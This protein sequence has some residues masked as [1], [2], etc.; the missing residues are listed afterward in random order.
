MTDRF[1][2]FIKNTFFIPHDA[3]SVRSRWKRAISVN[4]FL[5]AVIF[6]LSFICCVELILKQWM[7]VFLELITIVYFV[8]TLILNKKGNFFLASNLAILGVNFTLFFFDSYLG[9]K[10]GIAFYY[11]P[12]F[13]S[14]P[15]I[16][17]MDYKRS[18]AFHLLFTFTCW[19]ILE[20][21]NHSLLLDNKLLPGQIRIIYL[22]NMLMTLVTT[23]LYLYYM[24]K[25][26]EKDIF[27]KE[28]KKLKA[29]IDSNKQLIMLID[30]NWQVEIVNESFEK[31]IFNL[32]NINIKTN[33]P[34]LQYFGSQNREM[35]S[36]YLKRAFYGEYIV[37]DRN[38]SILDK[39][40]WFNFSFAPILNEHSQIKSV[41][42]CA[43]DISKTK[44]T[45][46]VLEDK[47]KALIKLNCQLDQFIYRITHDLKAPLSSISGLINLMEVEKEEEM[48]EKYYSFIK[49]SIAR[50]NNSIS[51]IINYSKNNKEQLD[52][53]PINFEI[54]IS[55]LIESVK[56]SENAKD[57]DFQFHVYQTNEFKND[58]ERLN[59]ILGNLIS[60]AIRYR[61]PFINNKA[62]VR[63]EVI[64][65]EER[66]IISV[67]DNG[68]GIDEIHKNK[69]FDM[70]YRASEKS[71][72]GLGLFIVKEV[73]NVIGGEISLETQK[74]VG[75]TF[76]VEIPNFKVNEHEEL[77]VIN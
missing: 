24:F 27:S 1:N 48:Q 43:L 40:Y 17:G 52:I 13:L 15:F 66:A 73:V 4:Y 18:V 46:K 11:Y 39:F 6:S 2:N 37:E 19:A 56:F 21:S 41:V 38:I 16:I 14:I 12:L 77:S 25:Y 36:Q 20:L 9:G 5:G 75:T 30:E 42:F 31:H 61:N 60:N 23:G 59:A 68:V 62:L 70:F 74:G 57:I 22:S 54:F 76:K 26:A 67:I 32:Y 7:H 47:N 51:T 69:V 10:A 35:L 3:Y 34:F 44:T 50:L 29:V 33:T 45:E 28:R 53:E 58:K 55:E 8:N 63:I 71:G 49:K 72:S 65:F 64:V